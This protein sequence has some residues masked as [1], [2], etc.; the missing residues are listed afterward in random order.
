MGYTFTLEIPEE[1][2]NSLK[3]TANQT[4]Q[5]PEVLAVELLINATKN[6]RD[7]PLEQFIGAFKSDVSNWADEHDNYLG[8]FIT[9][10]KTK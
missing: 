7:D 8:T 4:G 9:E 5:P 3:E 10:D 1:V 6:I 2:Y